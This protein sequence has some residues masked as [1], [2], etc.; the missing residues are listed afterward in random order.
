MKTFLELCEER[1]SARK[2]TDE[3]VS[4]DD[5]NY[6]LECVRLAP[7]AVNFQPW[8]WLV[9]KSEEAKA[10]LQQCYSRDWFNSAPLYIVG[11]KDTTTNWVR[12]FDGKMHGD[13]DVSIATE[14][15]CLAATEQGLGTCWV[16]NFDAQKCRELLQLDEQVEPA[17]LIPIGYGTDPG[18][19]KKRKEMSDIIL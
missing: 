5:L 16:C 10:K 6:I 7:S 4:D 2:F 15:L 19:E 9:V 13:V 14:H 12:K 11:L 3:P 1:F 17:V 8:K 18:R